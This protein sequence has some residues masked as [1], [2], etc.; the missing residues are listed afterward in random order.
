MYYLQ[1]GCQ[2][3][4]WY[5]STYIAQRLQTI[6]SMVCRLDNSRLPVTGRERH[7]LCACPYACM[8]ANYTQT[9]LQTSPLGMVFAEVIL[10]S[11]TSP[12]LPKN[13]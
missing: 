11:Q 12:P 3:G 4:H 9:A 7:T 8:H 13:E 2:G 10:V 5:L 1:Q 6:G